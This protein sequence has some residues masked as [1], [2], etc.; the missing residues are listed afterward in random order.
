MTSVIK[1][2]DFA[3]PNGIYQNADGNTFTETGG[4]SI[5]SVSAN[6]PLGYGVLL[7][8]KSTYIMQVY[9][10]PNM[11]Y[12]RRFDGNSTWTDWNGVALT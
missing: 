9:F 3:Q 10:R 11:I 2:P 7:V 8:L 5:G 1:K 12:V 6:L 4:Y